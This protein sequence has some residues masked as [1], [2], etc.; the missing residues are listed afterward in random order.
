MKRLDKLRQ[1]PSSINIDN[2]LAVLNN[3]SLPFFEKH[4]QIQAL[5]DLST[6]YELTLF[7]DVYSSLHLQVVTNADRA[8]ISGA[9]LNNESGIN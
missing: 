3:D 7:G 2:A 4:K 5:E 9:T 1:K 6:G 8:L